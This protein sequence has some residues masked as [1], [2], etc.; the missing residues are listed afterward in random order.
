MQ[1]MRRLLAPVLLLCIVS[2]GSGIEA[3]LAEE[4]PEGG[5]KPVPAKLTLYCGAGIRPAAEALIAAFASEHGGEIRAT[6][7]GSEM[8]LGQISAGSGGD[9]F[10]P[11]AESYVDRAIETGPGGRGDTK[12]TAAYFVPADLRGRRGIRRNIRSLE[13]FKREGLRLGL[14]R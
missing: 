14:G 13:D 11:G 8:L 12:R 10:M 7:A 2:C 5:A 9:L 3:P 6:Y 4:T 1:K